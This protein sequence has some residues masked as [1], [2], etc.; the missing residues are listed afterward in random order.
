MTVGI[1]TYKADGTMVL[2]PDGAGGVFVEYLRPTVGASYSKTYTGLTGLTIRVFQLYAGA[3]TWVVSTDGFGHPKI[4][5]TP[6]ADSEFL[7]TTV[8]IFAA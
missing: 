8:L 4:D 7:G 3:H 5:F 2:T 6:I 1:K